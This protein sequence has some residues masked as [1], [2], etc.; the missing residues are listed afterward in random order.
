MD[1]ISQA[2]RR[3]LMSRVRSANTAPE[4][5]IRSMVHRLGF[6]FRL[7]RPSLPGKPDLI[8]PSRKKV[9][10]VHGCFW[11]QHEGCKRGRLPR[12]NVEFWKSKL[13]E[14]KF[15]DKR[16]ATKLESMGWSTFTVWE[17]ELTERRLAARIVRFLRA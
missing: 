7:R 13:S 17:C 8:F 12:T 10:F 15:R 11:H 1:I 4:L 6:R 5:A 16:V 2:D 14:N 9:L 3:A